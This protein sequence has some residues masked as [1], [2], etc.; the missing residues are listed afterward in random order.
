MVS[1]RGEVGLLRSVSR[2]PAEW[3]VCADDDVVAVNKPVGVPCEARDPVLGDALAARIA[4]AF[5][6]RDER[7]GPPGR[8]ALA[9]HHSLDSGASGVGLFGRTRGPRAA[10]R[11][12]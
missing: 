2:D 10:A 1:A 6:M 7:D 5:A 8:A 3:I 4:P 11:G 9:L 12:P